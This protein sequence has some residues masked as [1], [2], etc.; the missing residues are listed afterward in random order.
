MTSR[1]LARCA[2]VALLVLGVA[3]PLATGAPAAR[4]IGGKPATSTPLGTAIVSITYADAKAPWLGHTCGGVL[5]APQLV[6]TARHC[7]D[8][9]PYLTMPRDYDV[10]LGTGPTFALSKTSWAGTPRTRVQSIHRS[11]GAYLT[12]W[13]RGADLA[14][15]RLEGALPGSSTIAIAHPGDEAWWGATAARTTGVNVYGWGA[16]VDANDDRGTDPSGFPTL[17]QTAELPTVTTDTC[18]ANAE[19]PM[20]SKNYIC[21]GATQHATGAVRSGCTGDS[22]GPLVATDPAAAAGDPAAATKVVGIVS[23]GEHNECGADYGRYVRVADYAGWIDGFIASTTPLPSGTGAPRAGASSFAKGRTKISLFSNGG[24]TAQQTMVLVDTPTGYTVE[25]GRVTAAKVIALPLA[26]SKNG[27]LTVRLRAVDADGNESVSSPKLTVRT[28][29]DRVAPRL[30]AATARS[31]GAGYWKLSWSKPADDD[32][33]VAVLVETR[34]LG[35]KGK[36]KADSVVECEQCWVNARGRVALT[37]YTYG[38]KG[39]WQFRV[40]PVD[41]ALNHGASVIAK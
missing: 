1:S 8:D 21:A 7:V 13:N 15:L 2:A 31:L 24:G 17:L 14:L 34:K 3:V 39:K 11:P 12:A 28:K 4:V 26:P 10:A 33:V 29:V 32:R 16:T 19:F 9:S 18:I 25:A 36:W 27:K 23:F 22:G 35:S 30:R 37:G 5:V 40:T 6:L 20:I 41:R 38:L